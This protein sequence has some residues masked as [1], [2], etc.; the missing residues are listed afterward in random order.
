MCWPH[1]LRVATQLGLGSFGKLALRS[2]VAAPGKTLTRFSFFAPPRRRPLFLGALRIKPEP[3]CY[4]QQVAG[5]VWTFL[6]F[7]S[8]SALSDSSANPG[9][10]RPFHFA[11]NL[12]NQFGPL[13][14]FSLFRNFTFTPYKGSSPADDLS[15]VTLSACAHPVAFE[16]FG[17]QRTGVLAQRI[18]PG[19]SLTDCL[20][21]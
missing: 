18:H 15:R 19:N 17:C 21:Q 1:P 5:F 11:S 20:G 12:P 8:L 4:F 9:F 14:G 13:L 2:L 7:A 16:I 6:Q 10:V 3:F